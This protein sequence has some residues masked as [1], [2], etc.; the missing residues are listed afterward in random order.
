VEHVR[1]V[2]MTLLLLR[3]AD[4]GRPGAFDGPDLQRPISERGRAQARA[5]VTSLGEQPLERVLASPYQRCLETVQPLAGARGLEVEEE[6]A[7]AEGAPPDLVGRLLR[8]LAGRDVL[9][10][11][12]GPVID[13]VIGDLDRRGRLGLPA[14]WPTGSVWTLVGDL[15]APTVRYQPPPV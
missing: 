15:D 5:L 14:R 6:D 3:H 7:L 9:L 1:E 13:G 10:C 12:H 2:I 8:R 11:T 4:A